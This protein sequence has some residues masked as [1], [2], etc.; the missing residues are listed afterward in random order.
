MQKLFYKKLLAR[1]GAGAGCTIQS[2]FWYLATNQN[3]DA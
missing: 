3:R 1:A 2:R